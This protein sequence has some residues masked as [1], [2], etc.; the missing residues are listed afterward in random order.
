MPLFS[1][2]LAAETK[3]LFFKRHVFLSLIIYFNTLKEKLGCVTNVFA[4]YVP[5]PSVENL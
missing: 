2:N 4:I 1:V 5:F 3:M